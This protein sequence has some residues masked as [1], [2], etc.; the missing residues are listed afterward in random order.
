MGFLSFVAMKVQQKGANVKYYWVLGATG[1]V[2]RAVVQA[3]LDRQQGDPSI[4]VVAVGH[5]SIDAEVMERTH[6]LMSDLGELDAFWLERFP[7][8]FLIHCARLGGGSD[9]ARKRAARAGELANSRLIKI[10][11]KLVNKPVVVYC[12]GTLML[13]HSLAPLNEES[14]LNPIAYAKY[15]VRGE[16]PWREYVGALDVRMAL[17]AWILGEGSW[18]EAFYLRP[19]RESGF[20][21]IYGDGS[22]LMNVVAVEDVAG[23]LVHLAEGGSSGMVCTIFG[24]TWLNQAAFAEAV[25]AELGVATR[26][27]SRE[28]LVKKYGSTVAEALCSSAPITTIHKDWKAA[29]TPKYADWRTLLQ[30]VLAG[31]NDRKPAGRIS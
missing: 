29:Y 18:F 13:G 9:R 21:P 30:A 6:F 12:S 3:L 24:D 26:A 31:K 16:A 14:P 7:P 10:L 1:F 25:A 15:Y 8:A 17:P 22:Q 27:V 20:V 5:R 11:E 28:E 4:R 2:G 19:A 23:Q